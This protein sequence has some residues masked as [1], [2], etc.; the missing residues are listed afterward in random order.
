MI[1]SDWMVLAAIAIG[2]LGFM[3]YIAGE[4]KQRIKKRLTDWKDSLKRQ[5]DE[6]R[7]KQ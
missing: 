5:L 3:L 7:S 6:L 4:D 2:V 1:D